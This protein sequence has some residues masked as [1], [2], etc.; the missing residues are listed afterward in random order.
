MRVIIL[1][2]LITFLPIALVAQSG[3]V[4]YEN[5]EFK[6]SH[7]EFDSIYSIFKVERYNDQSHHFGA[8]EIVGDTAFFH[9]NIDTFFLIAPKVFYAFDEAID[10]GEIRLESRI[11]FWE[12][13]GWKSWINEIDFIIDDS[14]TYNCAN[15]FDSNMEHHKIIIPISDSSFKLSMSTSDLFK[16]DELQIE[17][18][19]DDNFYN[20][21]KTEP[22]LPLYDHVIVKHLIV[23]TMPLPALYFEMF[24]PK[25]IKLGG[26]EYHFKVNLL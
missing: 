25:T 12:A 18:L 4:V 14:I 5:N 24:A 8:L 19:P 6:L 1:I 22:K 21:Q 3:E 7:I 9:E 26:I 2:S 11:S 13:P 17:L 23:G 20:F 15:L 16:S 10:L